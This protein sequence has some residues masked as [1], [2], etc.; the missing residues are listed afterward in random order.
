MASRRGG[1]AHAHARKRPL[2]P[3]AGPLSPGSS[4]SALGSSSRKHL[5]PAV[6]ENRVCL[7]HVIRRCRSGIGRVAVTSDAA[8][9][10]A[11][12]ARL[13]RRRSV[14]L[15]GRSLMRS[16]KVSG[17]AGRMR[18]AVWGVEEGRAPRLARPAEGAWPG[19]LGSPSSTAPGMRLLHGLL[20]AQGCRAQGCGWDRAGPLTV[21][22]PA[23]ASSPRHAAQTLA[24]TGQPA[25]ARPQRHVVGAEDQQCDSG[26]VAGPHHPMQ[27]G[28]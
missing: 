4:R 21:R 10:A 6:E 2:P 16:R 7:G 20:R 13:R 12:G 15:G 23:L 3:V 14:R 27:E 28:L 22:L 24:R 11:A 5:R 25:S 1:H 8:A 9:A 18:A 17:R 26:R 19:R